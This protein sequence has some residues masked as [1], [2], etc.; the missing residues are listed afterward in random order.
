M[1]WQ[2]YVDQQLLATGRVTEGAI[3]GHD[4]SVWAASAGYNVTE[5]A[6][7]APLFANPSSAYSSGITLGGVKYKVVRADERS[8]Y[9]K[10]GTDGAAVVKTGQSFVVGTYKGEKGIQAGQC[11]AVV[12]K[13]GD[14]L[15][16]NNF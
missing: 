8:I 3:C 10:L 11:N 9:A 6:A 5:G 4:G 2:D 12:E 1:S 7:I 15:I 13:L 14:Y 16:E